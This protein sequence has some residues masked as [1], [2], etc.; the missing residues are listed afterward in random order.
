MLLGKTGYI[1]GEKKSVYLEEN[2]IKAKELYQGLIGLGYE[3][4]LNISCSDIVEDEEIKLI[5][6]H[7]HNCKLKCIYL[8]DTYGGML[9][10]YIPIVLHKF[11]L[12]LDKYSSTLPIGIHL[13][14]NNGNALTRV[15]KAIFHGCSMI[16]SCISGLGRGSGNLEGESLVLELKKYNKKLDFIPLVEFSEK[17]LNKINDYKNRKYMYGSNFYYLLS[18]TISLHPNFILDIINDYSHL[19]VKEKVDLIYKLSDYTIK[20]CCRN[21]DKDLIKKI[22]QN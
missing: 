21:Y 4:C 19:S 13:H 11:Y 20:N 14:N 9:E 16:D 5:I 15:K 22:L 1:D 18:G 17:H 2:I 6:K 8:A 12:E 7:F 3:V 10:E